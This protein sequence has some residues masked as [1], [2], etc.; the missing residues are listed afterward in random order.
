[1]MSEGSRVDSARARAQVIDA[2]LAVAIGEH[3]HGAAVAELR[4]AVA[5]FVADAKRAMMPPQD[6]ILSLKMHV[7]R[8]AQ[9]HMGAEDFPRLV[10]TVVGW[11]IEEYYRES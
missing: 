10:G 1:M 4:R 11:G 2:E 6:V 3:L 8:E 5:T 9:P 7:Q